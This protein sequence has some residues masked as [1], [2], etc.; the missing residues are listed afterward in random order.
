METYGSRLVQAGVSLAKVS[1]L[2]GHSSVTTTEIY[3]HLAPNEVSE[4]AMMVLNGLNGQAHSIRRFAGIV[5][6]L[7]RPW[8][9]FIHRL[10]GTSWMFAAIR[11]PD[12]NRYLLCQPSEEPH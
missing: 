2:L 4:E 1:K 6:K 11:I 12:S 3:A 5:G 9:R 10:N 8:D 7:K